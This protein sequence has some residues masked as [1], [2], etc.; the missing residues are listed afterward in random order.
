M[1]NCV[2]FFRCLVSKSLFGIS[3]ASSGRVSHD[4]ENREDCEQSI[5]NS[6]QLVPQLTQ[7]E[8]VTEDSGNHLY[9][10]KHRWNQSNPKVLV[11]DTHF[12]VNHVDFLLKFD[13]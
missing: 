9:Q 5:D 8:G 6:Q 2:L 13:V 3:N 4:T 11:F 7:I 12:P 10:Q 1:I